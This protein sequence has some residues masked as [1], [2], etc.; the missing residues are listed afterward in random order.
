MPAPRFNPEQTPSQNGQ[1]VENGSYGLPELGRERYTETREQ[2][3]DPR[4]ISAAASSISLPTPVLVTPVPINDDNSTTVADGIPLVANDDDLIEKEWVDKAKRIIH[5]TR[6]DPHRREA[7][8]SR[9]QVEYL[10]K[11]YGKELGA[12]F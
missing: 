8:I 9:L 6:D 4:A 12:S 11:R 3:Q 2:I 1:G 5:E 10:R 7:E